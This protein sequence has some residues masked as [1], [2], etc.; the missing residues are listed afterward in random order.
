LRRE[1]RPKHGE[2]DRGEPE[3]L[4]ASREHHAQ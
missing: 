2:R 1:R 3:R 4:L